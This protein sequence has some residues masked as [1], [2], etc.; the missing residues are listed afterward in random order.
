MKDQAVLALN[1]DPLSI[2]QTKKPMTSTAGKRTRVNVD[3]QDFE[4]SLHR[5]GLVNS[6]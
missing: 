3:M 4:K 2:P 5:L 1:T 6:I